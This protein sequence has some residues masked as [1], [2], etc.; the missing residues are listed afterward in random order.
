ML[1]DTAIYLRTYAGRQEILNKTR[2][3]TQS[4]RLV[5]IMVDGV[6]PYRELRAKLP[7]LSEQRFERAVAKL[8]KSEL[9]SEVLLPVPGQARD[10]ID[11]SLVDRFLQQDPMDPFTLP[12]DVNLFD[13]DDWQLAPSKASVT[14]PAVAMDAA[15]IE[16]ADSVREEVH[17][18][19]ETRAPRL[20]P[21]EV[22]ASRIFAEEKAREERK[23]A[24]QRNWRRFLPYALLLIGLAFLAGFGVARLLT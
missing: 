5:L 6:A 24:K 23:K 1:P 10:E 8:V 2:A 9:I 22:A 3:L 16:L 18:F 20:E 12:Y 21:I 13:D 14:K 11:A 15:H 4:E 17:A 19:K 7:V